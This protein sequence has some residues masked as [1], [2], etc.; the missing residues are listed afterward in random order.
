MYFV[1]YRHCSWFTI[2]HVPVPSFAPEQ[3]C[4]LYSHL[5]GTKFS[6]VFFL[7]TQHS[8][9]YSLTMD[10]EILYLSNEQFITSPIKVI[11]SV[12]EYFYLHKDMFVYS[13]CIT[14]VDAKW[15]LFWVIS[16]RDS[17][18]ILLRCESVE[19]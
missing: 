19:N 17:F 8:D 12:K 14:P 3:I 11:Q 2:I 10:L 6:H 5:S 1:T 16:S 18:A 4:T 9:Q 7:T 13:L 15:I